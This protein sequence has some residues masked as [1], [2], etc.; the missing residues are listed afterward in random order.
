M[1]KK[2]TIWLIAIFCLFASQVLAQDAVRISG[3][4]RLGNGGETLPGASIKLKGTNIGTV[5]NSEG[6]YTLSVPGAKGILV[7]SYI[8]SKPLEV[9]IHGRTNIDV[10]LDDNVSGLDEV[11]V[12]G[13]GEQSRATVTGSISKVSEKEF[14]HAPGANPLLQMQG[15]VAGLS[16]QVSDGQPGSNPQIFI[17][18]GSSTSAEGD[19]PLFI[20]DGFVG[21]IRNI[22]DLN[23]DDI[24]SVQVLKD[25]ASMAI[26][27][28][29]A[30]NG[31][32]IVKTKSGKA[33]KPQIN[34]KV[35]SGI[36]QQAKQY[37]FISARDYIAVTRTAINNYS[38]AANKLKY[39]EGGTY[40][41]STG[42][43]RNTKHTLEFLEV[44][45]LNYGQDYV[46]YLINQAGWETMIDPVTNRELI[47][48]ET[49]FQDVT[50]QTG[51]KQE[52]D[53]NINGGTDKINY[54]LGMGYLNQDGI[55]YGTWYKN[56][57]VNF[58]GT[59]KLNDRVSFNT[60]LSY[61]WRNG[62][63][64][65]NYNNVLSRSVTMPFTERLYYEDGKPAPG[66]ISSSFRSRLHEVYYKEQYSDNNVYRTNIQVGSEIKVIPGLTFSP[67]LYW[68]TGTGL[69][70]RFEAYNEIN[71]NRDASANH[72]FI[73]NLQLDGLLNYT[74]TF[75]G[76]HNINA[77]LGTSY[78]Y[79]NS[80]AM[81]G[82]GY[83]APSDN[84]TT[85][86]ATSPITQKISTTLNEDNTM[87]YFGR[88]IYDFD[89]KY[90]LS[91]S[92]RYD[93][94]SKFSTEHKW[95]LFPGVS[96]GWNIHKEQFWSTVAPSFVSQL[97]L[98]ASWGEAG[99]NEI[100][101][102]DSQGAYS[103]GPAYT[104]QGQ[105]GII[106]TAVANRTLRWETTTSTDAGIDIGLFKDRIS[107]LL[108]YYNKVT[109]D[110]LYSKPLDYTSGFSSIK[111]N[112]GSIRSSGFEAEIS[113]AAINTKDFSWNLAFNFAY[114]KSIVL[115][116][117]ANG[118]DKSRSGG[119]IV[120]DPVQ[121]K[122]VWVGGFADG[123]R[124]GGRW[125]YHM[126][127]VYPTDAD[128][129]NAPF[130]VYANGRVKKGGDAIWD[131]LNGDG[132]IDNK[133]MVFMGYIRP[134][135]TGGMVNSFQYKGLG[136]RF[137]MDYGIGHVIDNGFRAKANGSSRNNNMA[138][139]DVL[140]NQIWKKPGDIA[141]IP[142]YTVESDFDFGYRN[143]VRDAQGIGNSSSNPSN[144]SLY[145]SKGDYLAFR[146]FS[147][148]YQLKAGFLQKAAIQGLELFGGVYNIGYLTKYDGLSP[149]IFTGN[150]PGQYPRPREY[151]FGLRA[152][153]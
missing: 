37:D 24:E 146:E 88:A 2:S 25:A 114:N 53:F 75:A 102:G 69:Q 122:E 87:S 58:K 70:N 64:A 117:P 111:S 43:P 65:S 79:Q 85:L 39:L 116:L 83:G 145:Y 27:G 11:I 32:I 89:A 110:R 31:I 126:I 96:A 109:S 54:Y 139:A 72:D 49:N 151:N 76:K 8:G 121:Q 21:A 99:N 38:S 73:K 6:K 55:V 147:L 103:T 84:I 92:V 143:H 29:R 129:L 127:G 57:N 90:I 17:R 80:F 9:D 41:M 1:N 137:V 5:T 128:A 23:P 115:H 150:D 144:S 113:A 108:D 91:A 68:Y 153:F 47:F 50:F 71:K 4:V 82:S 33:G 93:G 20:V 35:T 95:G 140:G 141:T 22:S 100:S 61:I 119:N 120:F 136:L 106:N 112:F 107:I 15:K 78:L 77:V 66:E 44:Y 133:D 149:E 28:A 81:S 135:K 104:Y 105:A 125:A 10:S 142:R 16:L 94:S 63:V 34:F 45:K 42:N 40:G 36:E 97:K 13:Y 123:E 12:I 118:Q 67:T 152:T 98:R 14:S 134:D 148:S 19:A 30:A 48:K 7:F 3:I 138:I 52:Y 131:D 59:Y 86:N 124:Y 18:G 132:R 26:Y 62:D 130:D 101:I 56:Y 74:K 51:V 46:D 60:N